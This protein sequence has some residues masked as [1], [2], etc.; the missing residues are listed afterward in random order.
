MLVVLSREQEE[1]LLQMAADLDLPPG[2][3]LTHLVSDRLAQ[4]PLGLWRE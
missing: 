2:E 3:L 1:T 4:H